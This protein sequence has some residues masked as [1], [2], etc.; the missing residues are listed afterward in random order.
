[1]K[2]LILG[3]FLTV[4]ISSF[5][6]AN[7]SVAKKSSL[8]LSTSEKQLSIGKYLKLKYTMDCWNSTTWNDYDSSGHLTSS[9][10]VAYAGAC[11]PGDAD[12]TVHMTIHNNKPAIAA[13]N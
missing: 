12:G 4:G 13:I 2:K 1:M 5:A 11:L 9:I 10:T 6:M 8:D 7:S 3:L